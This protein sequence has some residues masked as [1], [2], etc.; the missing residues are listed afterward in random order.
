MEHPTRESIFK[1]PWVQSLTGIFSIIV[2]VIGILFY[3]G[4]SS[5]VSI[6][7]SVVSAP[8]ITIGPSAQ[9]ILDEVYVKAG[10]NVEAG[11]SLAHIGTE[12]LTAKVSGLIIDVNNNPGQLFSPSQAI[13]KM[14]NPNELRIVGTVKETE[15][16]SKISVGNPATFTVDAFGSKKYTG[17]VEEVSPTSKDSSVVFSI[18][19]KRETK[20]F[21]VKV[22]YDTK[23]YNYFKN[24]MSAKMKVYFK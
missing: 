13:V 19:D 22:K 14:I 8:V 18:S 20:E 1:K 5:R 17:I 3:K 4:I 12:V 7:N 16:L 15:G 11:Q 6:E 23:T 24:G 2:I 10:D 21:N 9:G